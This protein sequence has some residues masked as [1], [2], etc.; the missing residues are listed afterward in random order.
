VQ[1][2]QLYEILKQN[3]QLLLLVLPVLLMLQLTTANH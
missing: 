3:Y 1:K 2:C